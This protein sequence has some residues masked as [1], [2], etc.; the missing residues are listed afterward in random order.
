[1]LFEGARL[2][3]P[4]PM[5]WSI[6][7]SPIETSLWT[8]SREI[9]SNVL[10]NFSVC[11]HGNAALCGIKLRCCWEQIGNLWSPWGTGWEPGGTCEYD[12]N[13]LGTREK[14]SL[15]V[16]RCPPRVHYTHA[17]YVDD[18]AAIQAAVQTTRIHSHAWPLGR[19]DL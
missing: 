6:G 12:G 4:S 16:T 2:I 14:K 17:T 11:V 7:H 9:E 5:F 18:P 1:M 8:P 15:E 19:A 13:T 3:D 10:P